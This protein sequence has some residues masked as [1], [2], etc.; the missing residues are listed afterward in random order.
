MYPV[1]TDEMLK[2]AT[3]RINI[4]TA[5]YLAALDAPLTL[6]STEVP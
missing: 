3:E 1:W 6:Y 2:D 4:A 5:P